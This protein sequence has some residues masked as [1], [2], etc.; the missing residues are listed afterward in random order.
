MTT[1]APAKA[2]YRIIDSYDHPHGG[3]I[4]RLRLSRGEALTVKEL[5]G[6]T[7]VAAAPDGSET[8]VRV[9]GFALFGGKPSNA[10]LA[11]TGRADVHVRDAAAR[12]MGPGWKLAGPA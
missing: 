4:L 6:G 2:T 7:M 1:S 5:K 3:H 8:P 12:E 11:R 9:E 10:R